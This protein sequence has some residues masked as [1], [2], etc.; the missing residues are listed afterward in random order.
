[1]KYTDDA[2]KLRS[3]AINKLMSHPVLYPIRLKTD[4]LLY[5]TV[6][7]MKNRFSWILGT[8]MSWEFFR[9]YECFTISSC[10]NVKIKVS[11]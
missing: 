11:S 1:M 3:M 10:L 6:V 2:G 7:N 8:F 5:D 9:A 4:F